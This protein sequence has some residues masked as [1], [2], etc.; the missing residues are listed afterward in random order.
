MH[1]YTKSV[2]ISIPLF[3]VGNIGTI[4]YIV[5][6]TIFIPVH[7]TVASI[8]DQIPVRVVLIRIRYSWTVVTFIAQ[9]ISVLIPLVGIW[10]FGTIVTFIWNTVIVHIG[11]AKISNSISIRVF[12]VQVWYRWTIVTEKR[13]RNINCIYFQSLILTKRPLACR[14]HLDQCLPGQDCEPKD[15]YPEKD[16]NKNVPIC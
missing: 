12:L 10:C 15:S 13:Q 4:V 14:H 16:I 9:T 5:L 8:T 2:F 1:L 7:I 11:I 3:S 6:N